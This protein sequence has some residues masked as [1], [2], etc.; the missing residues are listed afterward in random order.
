MGNYYTQVR[1]CD[2]CGKNGPHLTIEDDGHPTY[3]VCRHCDK[4]YTTVD[5]AEFYRRQSESRQR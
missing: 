3:Y 4:K 1:V 2:K 5:E